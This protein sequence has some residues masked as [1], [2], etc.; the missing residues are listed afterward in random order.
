MEGEGQED[1]AITGARLA[2]VHREKRKTMASDSN[3]IASLE[4]SHYQVT[5][6][7]QRGHIGSV[8]AATDPGGV[9]VEV[10]GAGERGGGGG[11]LPTWRGV[12]LRCGRGLFVCLQS[13]TRRVAADGKRSCRLA[14]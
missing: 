4:G 7:Y 5:G 8:V 10:W 11:W 2:H 13:D 1:A 14:V 3:T 6:K 9:G 12:R